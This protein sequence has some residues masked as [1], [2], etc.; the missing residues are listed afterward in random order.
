MLLSLAAAPAAAKRKR[1]EKPPEPAPEAAAEPHVSG[2]RRAYA[3]AEK[4]LG[5]EALAILNERGY[6]VTVGK[7][8][9]ARLVHAQW[10]ALLA[11]TERGRELGVLASL[12]AENAKAP[13]FDG[14]EEAVRALR[15]APAGGLMTPGVRAAADLLAAHLAAA[16]ALERDA[17]ERGGARLFETEAGAAF[18]RW[19]R[20]ELRGDSRALAN[21]YFRLRLAAPEHAEAAAAHLLGY[22]KEARGRELEEA[23]GRDLA[24]NKLSEE[25]G[26]ALA[27]YL[28]DQVR[29]W[30]LFRT[31]ERIRELERATDLRRDLKELAAV[32]PRLGEDAVRELREAL[33]S[34]A[35]ATREFRVTELHVHASGEWPGVDTG[36]TVVVSASFWLESLGNGGSVEAFAVGFTDHGE[37]GLRDK[38]VVPLR[39]TESG[40]H[41]FKGS[42]ILDAHEPRTYRLLVSAESAETVRREIEITPSL[43][44]KGALEKLTDARVMLQSCELEGTLEQASALERAFA[45]GGE[46]PQTKALAEDARRLRAEAE[47]A[48]RAYQELQAALPGARLYSSSDQ[49]EFQVDRAERALEL[50]GTLPAGCA[51]RQDG[52]DQALGAELAALFERTGARAQRQLAFRQGVASGAELEKACKGPEAAEAYAGALA[53]LDADAAARCG[54]AEAEYVRVRDEALP[55]ALAGASSARS[56]E[57]ALAKAEKL[58]AG[59][60]HAGALGVLHPLAAGLKQAENPGCY[61]VVLKRAEELSQAAGVALAPRERSRSELG[62]DD[63][64]ELAAEIGKESRRRRSTRRSQRESELERQSPQAPE[65]GGG[66]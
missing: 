12:L 62:P 58:F 30:T 1:K 47:A 50:L 35:G 29:L 44:H 54:E 27:G 49:C 33:D 61:G 15:A 65:D 10:E 45:Q 19:A 42:F 32:L 6:L 24:A 14:D 46:R 64:A 53:L 16:H 57:D 40:P 56:A 11:L 3:L 7:G 36:D 39:L 55:R 4:S 18:M 37:G 28:E 38:S 43:A 20:P 25:L 41:V 8:N 60:D 26:G 48:S 21:E 2:E 52:A 5:A 23:L 9:D 13:A 63:T 34:P 51:L 17:L 59:G 22:M 66:R 31:P